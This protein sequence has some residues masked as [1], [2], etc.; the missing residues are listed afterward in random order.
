MNQYGSQQ[1]KGLAR[2]ALMLIPNFMKLMYRLVGDCRVKAGEKAILMAT[3]VYVISPLD[4]LPDWIPFLG[5]IDDLLLVA[6]ILNRFINSVEWSVLLEHWDGE[7][8]LLSTINKVFDLTR[9][10][11]PQ[12][13]YEKVVNKANQDFINADYEIK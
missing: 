11:L 12:G 1:N 9:H 2:Q 6:L 13:I 7:E 4:F 10:L 3:L 5:Q 8:G